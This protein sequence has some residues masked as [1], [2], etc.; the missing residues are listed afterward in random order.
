MKK[1]LLTLALVGIA[2][3]AAQGATLLG[4][5]V[6]GGTE[7]DASLAAVTVAPGISSTSPSGTLSRGAGAALPG[8]PAGNT[9][10]ASGFNAVD[11][12][13]ALSADDYFTF[14]ITPNG[15]NQM[16]LQ[17]INYKLFA[18]TSGATGGALFSSVGGFASTG[19]AI[20]TFP[21]SG[22]ANNDNTIALGVPFQNLS[23]AVEFRLYFFGGGNNTT[24]KVRFRSLAG[25]D[26]I[27]DGSVIPEPG[28][29][30]SLAF[31]AGMLTFV[32]RRR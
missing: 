3:V 22:N 2:A 12:A 18:T 28:T 23:S 26:L 16:T 8:S 15:G 14:S 20:S 1:A 5:E 6:T 17:S 29:L 4:W 19:A 24:D 10:G 25:D 11:L 30:L 27:I 7:S 21:I 9:F 32:R 13:G 31:G